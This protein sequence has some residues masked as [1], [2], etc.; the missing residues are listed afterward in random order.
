LRS[1]ILSFVRCRLAAKPL[2]RPLVFVGQA[3]LPRY[4]GPHYSVA[5]YFYGFFR[6]LFEREWFFKLAFRRRG[7][8]DLSPLSVAYPSRLLI[9]PAVLAEPLAAR[10]FC[11]GPILLPKELHLLFVFLRWPMTAVPFPKKTLVIGIPV[12]F[13]G[14]WHLRHL[15]YLAF[16]FV[17]PPV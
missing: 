8:E 7:S 2:D 15:F 9:S 6:N 5:L 16:I 4:G 10:S 12:S 3:V 1:P 14:P 11:W 17:F 13:S